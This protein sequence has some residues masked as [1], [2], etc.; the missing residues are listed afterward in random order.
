MCENSDFTMKLKEINVELSGT[1]QRYIN[2]CCESESDGKIDGFGA[3]YCKHRGGVT[4][5]I[6]CYAV[7]CHWVCSVCQGRVQIGW[8]WSSS[9]VRIAVW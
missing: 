5:A 7:V 6:W 2:K 4:I 3:G 1:S 9:L 8:G